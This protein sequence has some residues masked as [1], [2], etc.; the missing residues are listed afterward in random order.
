VCLYLLLCFAVWFTNENR[1]QAIRKANGRFEDS[2]DAYML[3][4]YL[5]PLAYL[6]FTHWREASRATAYMNN[7][8]HFQVGGQISCTGVGFLGV[9][10]YP[11]LILKPPTAPHLSSIIGAGTIGQL[12]ADISSGL[13]RTSPQGTKKKKKTIPL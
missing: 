3:F 5:V 7:W 6:P 2:V 12:L 10:H 9:L 4:V 8:V 13:S 11:L 1:M